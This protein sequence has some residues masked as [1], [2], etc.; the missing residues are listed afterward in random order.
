MAIAIVATAGVALQ[1]LVAASVATIARDESRTRA[2]FAARS[3]LANAALAPPEPGVTSGRT[4]DGLT[5]ERDVRRT[6][7][8]RLREVRVRIRD[9]TTGGHGVELV[10]VILVP[11]E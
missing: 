11:S 2:A 9:D 10:E 3:L 8:A 1:R 6:G 4:A 7:H 5:F